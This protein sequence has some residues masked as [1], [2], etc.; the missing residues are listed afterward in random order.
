M[1]VD[2]VLFQTCLEQWLVNA[3]RISIT[4]RCVG[5]LKHSIGDPVGSKEL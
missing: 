1:F 3:N 2:S 4:S 5:D